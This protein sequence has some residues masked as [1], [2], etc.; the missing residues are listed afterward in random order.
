MRRVFVLTTQTQD[1]FESLGFK[2]T[3]VETLPEQRRKVY[4]QSRKSKI[5]ALELRSVPN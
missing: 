2:E 3:T 5:F 4:D 1:W